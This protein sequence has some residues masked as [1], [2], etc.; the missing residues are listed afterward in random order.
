MNCKAPL[1]S[2]VRYEREHEGHKS[3]STR[4]VFFLT[5]E[6]GKCFLHVLSKFSLFS[7]RKTSNMQYNMIQ[8]D[9]NIVF[10]I[11]TN[12]LGRWAVSRLI[13]TAMARVRSRLIS[14]GICNGQNDIGDAFL[15][16]LRMIFFNLPKFFFSH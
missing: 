2:S 7:E 3:T 10:I 4:I 16:V 6:I 9:K 5:R 1:L 15:R 8:G 12:F 11:M 13:P 14:C